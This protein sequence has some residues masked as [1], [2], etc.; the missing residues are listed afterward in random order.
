[1]I[2]KVPQSHWDRTWEVHS[3]LPRPVNPTS[4]RLRDYVCRQFCEFFARWLSHADPGGRRL[5]EVGC[6]RSIWLPYFAKH[7]RYEVAGLDTSEIGCRQAESILQR[8]GVI[9]TIYRGDLFSP[10]G[11][12]LGAFDALV[13]LGLVEHFAPT[14]DV[15]RALNRLLRPAGRMI[16]VVPNMAGL[17]GWVQKWM[18][19]DVFRM[20]CILSP[21][22]LAKAH[23]DAGLRVLW[24]NY[25]LSSNFGVCNPGSTAHFMDPKWFILRALRRLSLAVWFCERTIFGIPAHSLWSPYVACVAVRQ[26]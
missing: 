25:F 26:R 13:S 6:A 24:S 17:V 9:G 5:I 1:M 22:S 18:S 23:E 20:H 7:L 12:L 19:R 21:K 15:L 2:S 14:S 3:D 16:T 4:V 11:E 10:P 8:E